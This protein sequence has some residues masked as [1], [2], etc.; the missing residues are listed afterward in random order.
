MPCIFITIQ[1]KIGGSMKKLILLLALVVVI[2]PVFG[3]PAAEYGVGSQPIGVISAM[4][5][6]LQFLIDSSQVAKVDEIG[7]MKFYAG[8]LKGKNVVLVKG[9]VGKSLSAACAATLINQ[10]HVKEIIFTG[11]AGGVGDTVKVL[12][13]V[14]GTEMVLHDYGTIGNE[15][16]FFW[17]PGP[18]DITRIPVDKG[19]SNLAYNTAV[20]IIGKDRVFQGLIATGD[21]FVASESYVKLLQDQFNALA[22]EMEGASVALVAY[23]FN[24]PCVVIRCMSDKADGLAHTSIAN[25]GTQAAEISEQIVLG[26]VEK[27]D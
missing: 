3:S 5:S 16:G 23:K 25:F 11:I 8:T 24:V 18:D 13:V 6:E 7:G 15:Q 21:Q 19:L 4:N 1:I 10:Y 20:S 17:R 27:L 9:G 22:C 14:V 26:L 12:D 2:F